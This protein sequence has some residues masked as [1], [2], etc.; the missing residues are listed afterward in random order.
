MGYTTY[1]LGLESI[2]VEA[3]KRDQRRPD[4]CFVWVTRSIVVD[5]KKSIIYVQSLESKRCS[6]LDDCWLDNM[7]KNLRNSYQ[8]HP[9]LAKASS[10]ISSIRSYSQNNSRGLKPFLYISPLDTSILIA[11]H[12]T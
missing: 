10:S 3:G 5:H 6:G 12:L 11:S 1:E 4:L 7:A 2:H 8:G 9:K